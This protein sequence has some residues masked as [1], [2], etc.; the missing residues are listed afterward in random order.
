MAAGARVSRGSVEDVPDDQF[1]RGLI[2]GT[3][4]VS[5]AGVARH[6]VRVRRV[7]RA[8]VRGP[9]AVRGRA[10]RRLQRLRQHHQS[11]ARR[12]AGSR[13][14]RS[15]SAPRGAPASA[16]RRWHRS[17]SGRRRSRASS[18]TRSAA[19]TTRAYCAATD[20]T[21]V[22]TGNPDLTAEESE[23][24]NVG[25]SWQHEGFSA[26][27]DY[28]DI[29]QE[30]KIDEGRSASPTSRSATTRR[31]PS[32]S[33]ARRWRVTPSG[34]LQQINATFDNI[35]EQSVNGVDLGAYFRFDA[36]R[37]HARLRPELH[38]TA[39]LRARGAGPGGTTS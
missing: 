20:Y 30:D 12:C 22:F 13:S 4:S 36:G 25:V 24:F 19:P 39:R 34:P 17:A 35:G 27:V 37:R 28:W 38:A 21:I 18:A 3:E 14:S 23:T 10:L 6:L 32:A 2:F 11:E 9:R 16:L 31:A 7:R 15:R 1:Q 26:S 5:A 8:A 33:A 29:T